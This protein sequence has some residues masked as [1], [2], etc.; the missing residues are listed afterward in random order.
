MDVNRVLQY[1]NFVNIIVVVSIFR[2]VVTARLIELHQIQLM[3][4]AIESVARQTSDY[5]VTIV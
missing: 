3:Q 1:L 2:V 5:H 4:W